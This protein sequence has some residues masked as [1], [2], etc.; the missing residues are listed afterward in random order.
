MP[1]FRKKP[2]C[3]EAW[4]FQGEWREEAPDWLR[5]R[6]DIVFYGGAG[7]ATHVNIETLEG[8]MSANLNDW[9]IRGVHGELY[10]CKPDIF[11]ATY[12]AELPGDEPLQSTTLE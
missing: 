10:P 12:D 6:Q 1:I 7:R 2:V 5:D 3:I 8:V 9:I 4:Q 11:A